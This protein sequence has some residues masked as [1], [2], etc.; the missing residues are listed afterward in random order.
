[1]NAMNRNLGEQMTLLIQA[2]GVGQQYLDNFVQDNKISESFY[3]YTDLHISFP[4]PID[5]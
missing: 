3:K 4:V 2:I 1:M 5:L